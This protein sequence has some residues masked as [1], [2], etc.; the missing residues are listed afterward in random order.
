MY[1]VVACSRGGGGL[2]TEPVPVPEGRGKEHGG[3]SHLFGYGK[4][5]EAIGI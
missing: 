3:L 5:G 2:Q 4:A 1:R